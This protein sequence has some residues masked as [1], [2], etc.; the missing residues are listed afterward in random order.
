[1]LPW[2]HTCLRSLRYSN[3][4]YPGKYHMTGAR[5]SCPPLR[6]VQAS[7]EISNGTR[8]RLPHVRAESSASPR[9]PLLPDSALSHQLKEHASSQAHTSRATST[10]SIAHRM[11]TSS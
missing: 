5:W 10:Q 11:P 1:M 4:P 8:Y 7:P 6:N 9:Q 2:C 3:R